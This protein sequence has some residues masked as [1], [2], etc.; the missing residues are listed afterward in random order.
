MRLPR[1]PAQDRR[2]LDDASAVGVCA[3][4]GYSTDAKLLNDVRRISDHASAGFS[5]GQLAGAR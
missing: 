2:M 1:E 3:P 4:H 5:V